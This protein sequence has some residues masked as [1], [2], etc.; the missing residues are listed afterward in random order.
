VERHYSWVELDAVIIQTERVLFIF[1]VRS[2]KRVKKQQ[3]GMK[4]LYI[5]AVRPDDRLIV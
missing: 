4:E 5:S 1:A 3:S 2:E